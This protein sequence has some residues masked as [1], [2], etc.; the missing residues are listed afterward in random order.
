MF[1][2]KATVSV[3][4]F[5]LSQKYHRAYKIMTLMPSL[6]VLSS[7]GIHQIYRHISSPFD[8]LLKRI[9]SLQSTQNLK[10]PRMSQ[11]PILDSLLSSLEDA[12]K[13]DSFR[14][15]DEAFA[16]L[17][18]L[19]SLGIGGLFTLLKTVGG[20]LAQSTAKEQE[21]ANQNIGN[22]SSAGEVEEQEMNEKNSKRVG[23]SRADL[24]ASDNNPGPSESTLPQP[25]FDVLS[26]AK[27]RADSIETRARE[28]SR[29]QP[30]GLAVQKALSQRDEDQRLEAFIAGLMRSSTGASKSRETRPSN[31]TSPAKERL[32]RIQSE[33]RMQLLDTQEICRNKGIEAIQRWEKAKQRPSKRSRQDRVTVNRDYTERDG[34]TVLWVADRTSA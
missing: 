25:T 13:I 18:L 22:M 19:T 26:T 31:G 9:T 32:Q 15:N 20:R 27:E 4:P 10:I 34:R 23:N 7:P 11:T 12:R 3:L 5:S 16:A 6:F 30:G 17:L 2:Y 24:E 14:P 21:P 1:L 33:A 28:H 29:E 8:T